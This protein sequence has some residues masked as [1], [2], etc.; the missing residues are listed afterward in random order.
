MFDVIIIVDWSASATP[1]RGADSIWSYEVD[2]TGPAAAPINHRTRSSARDHLL[3]R[4]CAHQGRRVL[5]GFDFA[6]GYPSGFAARAGLPGASSWSATWSY[7]AAEIMDDER[8]RNNRWA[9]A[10]ALNERLGVCQ[11][12]GVPFSR[13]SDWL[14]TTKP[15]TTLA[16]HRHTEH[17]LRSTANTR[18]FSVWQLLGAGAVGSQ[19]LTGIPVLQHLRTHPSLADR[20]RVWPFETGFTADPCGGRR[21]AVVLAEVWPSAVS[22]DH[23]TESVKDARQVRALA[24]HFLAADAAGVL[25]A[26]FAPAIEPALLREIVT[27]EGWVLT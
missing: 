4:L 8:N 16:E 27:E 13:R 7:L 15:P 24:E 5:V 3:Q 14:T 22:C 12:W 18:P 20:V 2:V 17:R 1:K 26:A 21:D 25:A 11:F 6:F 23:L 19:T 10:A 9:V